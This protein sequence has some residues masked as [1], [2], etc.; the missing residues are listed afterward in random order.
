MS[1]APSDRENG[2]NVDLS[3]LFI[4]WEIESRENSALMWFS[5]G[6]SLAQESLP[7]GSEGLI[8]SQSFEV[9][10]LTNGWFA[11]LANRWLNSLLSGTS[12]KDNYVVERFIWVILLEYGNINKAV[13][14]D[15]LIQEKSCLLH[16]IIETLLRFEMLIGVGLWWLNIWRKE[17]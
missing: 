13:R 7:A 8:R 3:T 11:S 14:G 16:R 5:G 2:L 12:N 17:P 4:S 10:Y 15:P 6:K 1:F 9:E